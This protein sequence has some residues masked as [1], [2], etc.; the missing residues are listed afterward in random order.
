MLLGLGSMAT[1]QE[2]LKVGMVVPLTG[3]L[4]AIGKQAE[5]GA[6]LYIKT[7]GDIVAGRRIQLIVRDDAGVPDAAKRIAQELIVGQKA[8]VIAAGI[9][10]S[11]FAIAPL[12]T[13]AKIPEV[14]VVSGTSSLTER[15]PYVVRTSWTLGQQSEVMAK[16]AAQNGSK[17]TVVIV[18]DWAPGAEAA[19]VFTD[20]FQ[21]AGGETLETIKVPLSNPDFSPFLQRARDTH[22]DTFFV[23]VPTGQAGLFA[24]QFIERG[25]DK[26][27]I[28]LI[29]TGDITDDNDLPTMGDAMIG[30]TTAGFYSA[31]HPSAMN[32]AYVADFEKANAAMR[33]N[34]V[35][36]SAYDGMHLI[37]EALKKTNGSSK[38]DE[39]VAAMKGLAWESP[40]GPMSID[41]ETR[42]IIQNIYIRKVEKVGGALYNV[43]T[44]TY[45]AVKDPSKL[46]K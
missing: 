12:A 30:T 4:A 23:F 7:H 20:F 16:W 42:D 41:P 38:G 44:A 45:E 39:L 18:S 35:S 10:P 46:K 24:K 15:S 25:L 9:T 22:A 31:L 28:K 11:A 40:R 13:E 8:A 3:Q 29:G 37:Y 5:A 33:P 34:Y 6:T 2:V 27:G 43:E 21:K 1:A 14:A 32:K 26:S 17:K 36:V 19:A